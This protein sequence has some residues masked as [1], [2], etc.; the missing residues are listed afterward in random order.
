MAGQAVLGQLV[1]E[2]TA[3]RGSRST[4]DARPHAQDARRHRRPPGARQIQAAPRFRRLGPQHELMRAQALS[5]MSCDAPNFVKSAKREF[6]RFDCRVQACNRAEA[7]IPAAHAT[8]WK[9]WPRWRASQKAA[10]VACRSQPHRGRLPVLAAVFASKL[11]ALA[12]TVDAIGARRAPSVRL[13]VTR[14][15]NFRRLRLRGSPTHAMNA[16]LRRSVEGHHR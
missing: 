6:R 11:V 3:F 9:Q 5:A 4:S 8:R 12:R 13:A 16:F 10:S 1:D 14:N 15:L 7:R 2:V